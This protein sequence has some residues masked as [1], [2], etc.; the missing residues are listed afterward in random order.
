MVT[1]GAGAGIGAA[2]VRELARAGWDVVVTDAHERRCL[3]LGRE[4][5]REHGRPF[6]A[7][8][9][10]VTDYDAVS[11]AVERIVADRGGLDGLVNSAG[12]NRLE[13]LHEMDPATWQ[14]CID[15]DL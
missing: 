13:P 8:P 7:I 12:F 2:I 11:A 1:A 4:L 3:E 15:V 6:L 5:E 10:D 9:L 14:R